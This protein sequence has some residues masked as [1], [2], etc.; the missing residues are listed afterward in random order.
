MIIIE[1]FNPVDHGLNILNG[2]KEA[3]AICREINSPMIKINWD[4]YHMQLTEGALITHLKNG[5]DQVGYLQLADT[6]GRFQPGTGELNYRAILKAAWDLG[7]RDYVGVECRTQGTP[8]EALQQLL[9]N[10]Y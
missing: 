1:P 6:P 7:Y 5:Y 10:A 9:E 3:L 2:S 8:E 4:F